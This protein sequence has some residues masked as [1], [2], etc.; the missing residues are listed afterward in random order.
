M[1]VSRLREIPGIGVDQIGDAADAADDPRLPMDDPR[2]GLM[3]AQA[4]FDA[5]DTNRRPPPA[6]W[7]S[8]AATEE[9]AASCMPSQRHRVLRPHALAQQTASP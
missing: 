2:G 3:Y 1:T 4:H 8:P 7:R 5:D 6:A 9:D